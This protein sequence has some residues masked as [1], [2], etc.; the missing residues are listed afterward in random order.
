M[1]VA[2]TKLAELIEKGLIRPTGH[3][4]RRGW[5]EVFD[6]ARPGKLMQLVESDRAGVPKLDDRWEAI[7]F[8]DGSLLAMT[9]V[10]GSDNTDFWKAF[11][12][13]TGFEIWWR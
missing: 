5:E 13:L 12:D 4:H 1:T 3:S 6:A 2:E 11:P 8:D 7:Q 10:R 9:D